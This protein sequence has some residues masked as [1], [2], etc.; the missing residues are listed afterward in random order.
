MGIGIVLAAG[1]TFGID[2][3]FER[4]SRQDNR[5]K[6]QSNHAPIWAILQSR[7]PERE[8]DV[9]RNQEERKRRVAMHLPR[10][11]IPKSAVQAH[12]GSSNQLCSS[13]T[14][15]SSRN[16]TSEFWGLYLLP[17]HEHN[18]MGLTPQ[19][20]WWHTEV[21]LQIVWQILHGESRV[22]EDEAQP[23]GDYDCYATLL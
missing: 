4:T 6:A 22:R 14:R 23:T 10:F 13:P 19:S 3:S 7:I 18:P 8:W 17:F 20:I 11:P 16:R 9:W 2:P 15:R 12:L 1:N 5:W 21:L